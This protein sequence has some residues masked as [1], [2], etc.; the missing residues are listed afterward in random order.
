MAQYSTGTVT[1][2][3]GSAVVTG[4]GTSWLAEIDA[5]DI[6]IADGDTSPYFVQ[7]VDSD[8]QITLTGNHDTTQSGV[9][10]TLTRDFSTYYGIPLLNNGDIDLDILL[11]KIVADIDLAIENIN[12][13]TY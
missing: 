6:F 4:S 10:Y 3:S 9:T 13:G 5:D 11:N 1:T 12:G 8:T 7:S 2:T